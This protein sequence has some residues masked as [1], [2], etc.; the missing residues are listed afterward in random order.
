MMVINY[1]A[2]DRTQD[3]DM[4]FPSTV[5]EDEE[6]TRSRHGNTKNLPVPMLHAWPVKLMCFTGFSTNASWL[7][8]ASMVNLI[9]ATG[10]SG[11]HQPYTVPATSTNATA[12]VPN[13]IFVNGNEDF[14]IMAVC[15]VAFLACN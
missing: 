12:A 5:L 15:L 9:V 10:N 3:P 1:G 8:V 4:L 2:V 11:W 7:A 13:I 6:Q 14:T